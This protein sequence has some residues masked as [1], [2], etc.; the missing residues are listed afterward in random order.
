MDFIVRS[1]LRFELCEQDRYYVAS[2]FML[3][4]R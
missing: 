2:F 3:S 1:P 4:P